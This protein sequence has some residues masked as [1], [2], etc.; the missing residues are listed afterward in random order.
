[1]TTAYGLLSRMPLMK[2]KYSHE[3]GWK[4]KG[5]IKKKKKKT[6]KKGAKSCL[7]TPPGD[8]IDDDGTVGD[9][10]DGDVAGNG[11]SPVDVAVRVLCL[12]K[13]FYFSYFV[14]LYSS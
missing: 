10:A 11:S 2:Q 12:L 5:I 1:M 4:I 7:S 9:A 6:H 13:F 3:L 14:S 8:G